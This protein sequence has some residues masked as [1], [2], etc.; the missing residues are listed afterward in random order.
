[1]KVAPA[2]HVSYINAVYYVL[3]GVDPVHPSD[4]EKGWVQQHSTH[5]AW[6]LPCKETASLLG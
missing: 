5:G 1:L 2:Q 6:V 4:M 3:F